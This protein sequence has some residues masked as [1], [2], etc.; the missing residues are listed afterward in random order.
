[1]ARLSDR[2]YEAAEKS[3]GASSQ[4]I[5]HAALDIALEQGLS[6]RVLDFGAGIGSFSRLLRDSGRFESVTSADLMPQPEGLAD[7]HW[8]E[9]D[10]N[11]E[12][13]VEGRY[14]IVFALECIEHLENPRA[15][16]R[17]IY[18]VLVDGGTAIVTTPNSEN[19][20]GYLSLL[21]RRHFWA[22]TDL[23]YPQHIT[24]LLENDLR[25]CAL[26]AGFRQVAFDYRCDG[27]IPKLPHV[28]WTRL[29]L[30]GRLF[31]DN[32]VMTARK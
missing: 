22:F 20:R 24:A 1:V 9:A 30:R 14:D 18:R 13:V 29:G 16:L 25:R 28:R 6:G 31:C 7:I 23:T 15:T 5:Y 21:I 2:R 17:Q 19:L 12:A 3:G 11:D 8:I 10:L 4:R 27:G 32:V 26:E